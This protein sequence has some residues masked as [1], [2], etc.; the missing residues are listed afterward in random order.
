MFSLAQACVGTENFRPSQNS[1]NLTLAFTT[2]FFLDN[3]NGD[4]LLF[5]T[6]VFLL[7]ALISDVQNFIAKQFLI[8]CALMVASDWS[9]ERHC[10]KENIVNAALGKN[11]SVDFQK[12]RNK[13]NTVA[14]L[15]SNTFRIRKIRKTRKNNLRNTFPKA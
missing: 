9:R 6:C 4:G 14:Q 11:I 12:V 7:Y 1:S 10:K 8:F 2:K 3:V 13:F 15:Q 5:H